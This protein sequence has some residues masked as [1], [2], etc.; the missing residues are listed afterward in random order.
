MVGECGG[1]MKSK[2][3]VIDGVRMWMIDGVQI[4]MIDGVQNVDD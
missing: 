2:M 1:L 3:W 4:W